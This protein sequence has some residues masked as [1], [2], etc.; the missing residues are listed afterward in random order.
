MEFFPL[1]LCSNIIFNADKPIL[2]W[3]RPIFRIVPEYPGTKSELR[4]HQMARNCGV[5]GS[6]RTKSELSS[7]QMAHPGQLRTKKT[8]LRAH[9]MGSCRV[10]FGQFA[11]VDRAL[12]LLHTGNNEGL[13]PRPLGLRH[14]D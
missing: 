10:S 5:P 9:Q 8:E 4:P 12:E 3:T 13:S 2:D 7:H 14:Y 1:R 6:L 11:G